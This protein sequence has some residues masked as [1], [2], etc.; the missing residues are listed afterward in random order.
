[1]YRLYL[2]LVLLLSGCVST[3]L[4]SDVDPQ[5]DLQSLQSFLVLKFEP[6]RRGIEHMIATEL[7]A[8]GLKADAAVVRPEEVTADAVVTY[9]DKWMWDM[10]N[11]MIELTI[12]LHDPK[13]DY[14][15]ATARSYRT[16]LARKSPEE[17]V[18]EVLGKLF[19]E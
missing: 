2:L 19:D 11:Y 7:K 15:L 16:S 4:T 17:M 9:V 13:T 6:D 18:A 1:M 3:S 14:L 5:T 8:R 12:E 10:T